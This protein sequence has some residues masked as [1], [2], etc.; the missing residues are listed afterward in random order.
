LLVISL[1]SICC[2]GNQNFMKKPSTER[3]KSLM[4]KVLKSFKI[5]YT[6]L[7]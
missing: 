1:F 6:S 5:L 7:A 3:P 2:Q 4:L